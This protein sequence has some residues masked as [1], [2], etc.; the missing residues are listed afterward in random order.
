MQR[1]GECAWRKYGRIRVR[2]IEE[3][4]IT[5]HDGVGTSGTRQRDEVVVARIGC[6]TALGG[7]V[8][9]EDGKPSDGGDERT[10]LLDGRVLAKPRSDQD[11]L[12]LGEQLW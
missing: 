10:G 4:P 7:W 6:Q 11:A 1:F 12:E 2:E 5:G 8:L 3:V 9:D